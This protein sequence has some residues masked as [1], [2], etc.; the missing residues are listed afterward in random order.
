MIGKL[1]AQLLGNS[2]ERD[3]VDVYDGVDE[4]E[5][6]RELYEFEDGEW[7]IIDINENHGM[8]MPEMDPLENLL[9]EH[10][11]MSVYKLRCRKSQEEEVNMEQEEQEAEE[12]E[13]EKGSARSLPSRRL[14]PWRM[15]VWASTFGYDCRV[16]SLQGSRAKTERRKLT[17]GALRRR[18]L[19]K[20]RFSMA[21]Q[22][23]GHFKQ[24]R[25]RMYNF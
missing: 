5:G 2:D 7:V 13:R 19:A 24:P 11:S 22:R 3:M 6:C 4:N 12:E 20:M 17:H 10:P 14:I 18:N 8:A 9:I 21:E 16:L 25:Q 1:L 15:T 23:Y